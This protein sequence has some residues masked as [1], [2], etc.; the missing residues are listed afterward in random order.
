M[1]NIFKLLLVTVILL[2]GLT[3]T[4]QDKTEK[5]KAKSFVE[6]S[7]GISAPF[8]NFAKSDYDNPKAGF[9]QLGPHFNF[10]GAYFIPHTNFG[11]G[12]FIAYSQ[13]TLRNMQNMSDGYLDAFGVDSATVKYTKYHKIDVL[14]GP[15]YSIP[16]KYV[17]VDFRLLGGVTNALSPQ[18]KVY[19][20]DD[21]TD[22]FTQDKA[23]ATALAAQVGF[24]LRFT[25][26]PQ[27]AIALRADYFYSRPV[28]D[29]SNEN[30][31]VAAGRLIS[32]YTEPIQGI[33]ATLGLVYQF[34]K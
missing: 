26:I 3:G 32:S 31:V 27:F 33:N 12:G 19:L 11:F 5:I 29:I 4:A 28:F 25:P 34:G 7:A 14:I 15:Y 30:R 24:G 10:G 2:P 18:I 16:T 9:A 23:L 20:E 6:F 8:G 17:T 13:Y 21:P 1:R 22:G